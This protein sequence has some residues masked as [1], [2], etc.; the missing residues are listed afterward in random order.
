[1]TTSL[2]IIS[3]ALFSNCSTLQRYVLGDNVAE[4]IMNMKTFS[5][6]DVAGESQNTGSRTDN[7]CVVMAR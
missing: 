5:Y 6:C 2:I 4:K 3:N 1:M 7:R